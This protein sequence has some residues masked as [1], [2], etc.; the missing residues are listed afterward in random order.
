[1]ALLR[2][3]FIR[4]LRLWYCTSLPLAGLRV[5]SLEL[6]REERAKEQA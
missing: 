6:V 5:V 1:M 2:H 4:L 3:C